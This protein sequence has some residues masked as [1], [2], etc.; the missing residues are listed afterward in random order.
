MNADFLGA[1]LVLWWVQVAE[2]QF[3]AAIADIKREMEK[4][5]SRP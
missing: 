3:E 2:G 5:G 1:R 4:P